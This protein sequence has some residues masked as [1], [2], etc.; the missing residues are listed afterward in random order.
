MNAHLSRAHK[1]RLAHALGLRIQYQETDRGLEE[2]YR[3][4]IR[5]GWNPHV[6]EESIEFLRRSG[7]AV[8]GKYLL[9]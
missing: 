4:L 1:R 6:G 8:P 9:T 5:A 2:T 3:A 7:C